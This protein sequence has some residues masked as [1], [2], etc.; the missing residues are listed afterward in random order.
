MQGSPKKNSLFD[1]TKR[2][3]GVGN[4]TSAS[5]QTF[6]GRV[7]GEMLQFQLMTEKDRREAAA[8]ERRRAIEEERKKRIFNPKQRI[9]GT[10]IKALEQQIEEKKKLEAEKRKIDQIFDEQLIKSDQIALALGRKEYEERQKLAREINDFRSNFQKYEDRREFDLNDPKAI[11]RALPAR[12]HDADPRLGISSFQ[13]F[14]GEDLSSEER[15]KIQMEQ[16]QSW[17]QQQ[18]EERES[19][20][21][22][23]KTADE[24]Y[25]AAVIARD[26]RAIELDM[27]ERECRK[28]LERACCMF[29]RALA[30]ERYCVQQEKNRQEKE[31]NMAQMYNN[32]TSDMMTENPDVSFSNMGPNRRIGFLYKGMSE[33]EREEVR[34]QQLAQVEEAQ[35][36]RADEIRFQRE[37]DEYSNGIQKTIAVMDKELARKERERR[38]ALAEENK[39]LAS[40]H[41]NHEEYMNKIVYRNKPTAAFFEQFNKST[42]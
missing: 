14:E 31:D 2:H 39:R 16:T 9:I 25:K 3:K 19:A 32:M 12:V 23:R 20:D 5:R 4:A 30:D 22:E 13:K 7:F 34:K 42:R 27:M 15:K 41:K 8:I 38:I 24:A 36:R 21:K 18:M 28:R 35:K 29:N 11:K 33:E 10:D 1:Q 26:Q 37:W 6:Y 40:E 17:L